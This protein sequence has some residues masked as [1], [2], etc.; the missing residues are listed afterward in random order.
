MKSKRFKA[1][2]LLG[3]VFLL[4]ACAGPANGS[5]TLTPAVSDAALQTPVPSIVVTPSL[6]VV[7]TAATGEILRVSGNGPQG[8]IPLKLAA[9]TR[10]RI[11]WQETHTTAFTFTITN[12]DPKAANTQ[13]GKITIDNTIG[14][15]SS[16]VDY[17]FASGDYIVA[18]E[19]SDGPW[20][21]WIK[22]TGNTQ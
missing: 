22:A 13:N 8:G 15:A 9:D 20:E 2:A 17:L 10:I 16:Y 3:L 19:Q 4:A 18:V 5:P 7:P 12:Q 11:N 21:I 6:A 1:L 14:P